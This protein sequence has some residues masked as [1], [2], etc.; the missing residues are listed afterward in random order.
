LPA[1]GDHEHFFTAVDPTPGTR[2]SEREQM[3]RMRRAIEML[4]DDQQKVI[5]LR[6]FQ[7]LSLQEIAPMM[8]RSVEATTKLWYRAILK[9][10]ATLADDEAS[11]N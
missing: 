7:Q 1:N 5:E 10:R 9:L 4:P 8:N 6:N 3:E 11:R 2:L